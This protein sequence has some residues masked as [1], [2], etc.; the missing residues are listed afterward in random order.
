MT[1][2]YMLDDELIVE[3]HIS[4]VYIEKEHCNVTTGQSNVISAELGLF[5]W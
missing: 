5:K 4:Y 2:P 3:E 1:L